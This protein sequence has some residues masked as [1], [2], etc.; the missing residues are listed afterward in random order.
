MSKGDRLPF[1]RFLV[2]ILYVAEGRGALRR[3]GTGR[4]I[5]NSIAGELEVGSVLHKRALHIYTF[6]H[7]PSCSGIAFYYRKSVFT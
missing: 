3:G 5:H 4:E 6:S 2:D 7:R 1:M